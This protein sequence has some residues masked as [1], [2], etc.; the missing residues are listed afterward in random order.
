MD[1]ER[2]L[3]RA[4]CAFGAACNHPERIWARA[5]WEGLTSTAVRSL[6]ESALATSACASE[7]ASSTD[8]PSCSSSSE[9]PA[10]A[11][12]GLRGR[13]G[14]GTLRCEGAPTPAAAQD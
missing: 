11:W 7:A 9:T 5:R 1:M 8:A 10:V 4:S 2:A 13:N 14:Q 12:Y 6:V 3:F